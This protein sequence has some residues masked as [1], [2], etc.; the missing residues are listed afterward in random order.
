MFV[1]LSALLLSFPIHKLQP[2]TQFTRWFIN[3]QSANKCMHCIYAPGNFTE[4]QF[5]HPNHSLWIVRLYTFHVA[6]C[7][8]AFHKTPYNYLFLLWLSVA[9]IVVISRKCLFSIVMHFIP[10]FFAVCWL[11]RK[12]RISPVTGGVRTPVG[13]CCCCCFYLAPVR[14]WLAY[15]GGLNAFSSSS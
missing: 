1:V 12:F 5:H 14:V 13:C 15:M 7:S 3:R 6:C 9:A 4:T 8:S 10:T 2:L 11:H